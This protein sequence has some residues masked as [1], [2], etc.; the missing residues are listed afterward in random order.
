V[1]RVP[2]ADLRPGLQ[3]ARDLS[4]GQGRILLRRGLRIT[5]AHIRALE[6]RGYT[7]V[8]VSDDAS[9]DI[10]VEDIVSSY[11]SSSTEPILRALAGLRRPTAGPSADEATHLAEQERIASVI[12]GVL[13][14]DVLTALA[15]MASADTTLVYHGLHTA[16]VGLWLGARMGL[17]E[18]AMRS[19]A[20]ACMLHDCGKTRLADHILLL[21]TLSREQLGE[22]RDHPLQGM[23]MA[24]ELGIDDLEVTAA[25]AQ[26]H[27]RQDGKGYPRGL[28][29]SNRV[30]SSHQTGRIALAAEI[31]AVADTVAILLSDTVATTPL[32][33]EQATWTLYQ[34]S[35]T[36][37]NRQL[38]NHLLAGETR[39]PVGLR[40][41]VSSGRYAGFRGTVVRTSPLDGSQAVVRLVHDSGGGWIGPVELDTAE[42]GGVCLLGELS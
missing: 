11:I 9:D 4:D 16:I 6:D 32:Q 25:I 1:K 18:G 35:G 31:T 17:G 39:L 7:W 24:R 3:M 26:H 14:A 41:Y 10:V 28:R 38:V 22:L 30:E 42:E 37:L 5:G 21:P 29:G 13:S 27:E 40:V 23:Q 19:L 15:R 8:Y 33:P 2:V 20:T 36:V 34:L 12:G